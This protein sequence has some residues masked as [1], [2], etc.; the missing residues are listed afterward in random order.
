MV[1]KWAL[2]RHQNRSLG[3]ILELFVIALSVVSIVLP[4]ISE[5]IWVLGI[6]SCLALFCLITF[7]FFAVSDKARIRM[8][9]NKSK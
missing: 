6:A 8:F 9:R 3:R 7:A 5:E 1:Y 4:L 2:F